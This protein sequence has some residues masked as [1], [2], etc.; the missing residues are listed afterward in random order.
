MNLIDRE[1]IGREKRLHSGWPI[2]FNPVPPM[3]HR[4][5]NSSNLALIVAF[6]AVYL[7]WGSTYLAI[8]IA[9]ESMPPFLMISARFAVAGVVLYLFLLIKGYKSP[10]LLQW[11]NSA[12]MGAMTLAAGVGVV[13]WAEQWIDSGLAALLVTSVPLYM[14]L[15]EWLWKKGPRPD[16]RVISGLVLGLVGMVILLNPIELVASVSAGG[17]AALVILVSSLSWSWASI[18][19]RDLKLPDNVFMSTA[20]QMI[21]GAVAL[22][23]MGLISGEA[24]QVNLAAFTFGSWS[25][26]AYLVV[27]GSIVAFSAYVYLIGRASPGR[28]STY[29]YV[30]PVVAVILGAWLGGEQIGLRVGVAILVLLAAVFLISGYG[31]TTVPVKR[32][33]SK[34]SWL[35]RMSLTA[36]ADRPA[37]PASTD[38]VPWVLRKRS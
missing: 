30:N 24:S 9:L 28:I 32:R 4:R 17:F 13:A 22:L 7:I 21:M 26:W 10:S 6:A 12:I 2:T 34:D 14:I 8:K 16:H 19:G 37:E 18:L 35:T 11:K 31:S 27:F 3:K 38:R 1:V 36:I 20:A 25:A 33:V 23:I 5:V 29:A 15:L